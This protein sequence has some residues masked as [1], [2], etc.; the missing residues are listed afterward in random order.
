MQN[1]TIRWTVLV[2]AIAC[3]GAC[4][5]DPDDDLLGGAPQ[6]EGEDDG[7][8]SDA[9]KGEKDAGTS[10]PGD[11]GG[12]A[13]SGDAG[14]SHDAGD[15]APDDAGTTDPEPTCP[16]QGSLELASRAKLQAWLETGAYKC[17]A[18][19]SKVH[20]SAGPHLGNVKTY[21]ND[22]LRKSFE[23]GDA[24]HP[25][26]AIAVKELFRQSTTKVIGWAVG[27]K[28]QAKSNGGAGWYWYEI[29]DYATNN[30]DV[31]VG[32]NLA[33]CTNC[34]KGKAAKDFVLSPFPLQ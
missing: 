28:T 29:I 14:T 4:S 23:N 2:V 18:Q 13:P 15:Q 22:A 31:Y 32:Q 21:I 8:P 26:G 34:H 24:E 19:E 33:V 3:A 16:D 12:G 10:K 6:G 30:P 9:P 27:I 11:A 25:K 20:K 17:W 1:A 7:G 5:D